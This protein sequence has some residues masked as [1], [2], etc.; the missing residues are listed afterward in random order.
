MV[1]PSRINPLSIRNWHT[2]CRF[3]FGW[4]SI[5]V[6]LWVHFPK[7]TGE[8]ATIYRVQHRFLHP[9]IRW[10]YKKHRYE[11][12]SVQD[13]TG[14]FKRMAQFPKEI[15]IPCSSQFLYGKQ[16]FDAM[17]IPGWRI[18][19]LCSQA[20]RTGGTA[21]PS[22]ADN[23]QSAG[24]LPQGDGNVPAS[25]VDNFCDQFFMGGFQ[26]YQDAT[27]LVISAAKTDI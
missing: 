10:M 26:S 8:S 23:D 27:K 13:D 3:E 18:G 16:F 12:N 2:P 9:V 19:A 7:K 1:N 14:R 22:P 21:Q 15:V 20:S 5:I 25:M 17:A 11:N 6:T 24:E 4:V